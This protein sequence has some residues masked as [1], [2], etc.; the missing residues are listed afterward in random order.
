MAKA[1]PDIDTRTV[2]MVSKG[3]W[4]PAGYKE[5]FGDLSIL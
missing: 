3:R 5:K 2:E 1:R 4:M